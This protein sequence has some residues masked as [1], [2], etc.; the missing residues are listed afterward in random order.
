MATRIIV[1]L[2]IV[3]T[4]VLTLAPNSDVGGTLSLLLVVLGAVYA[5]CEGSA[6]SRYCLPL[7]YSPRTLSLVNVSV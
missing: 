1:S 3:V 6:A 2:A 4:M 7:S 5:G